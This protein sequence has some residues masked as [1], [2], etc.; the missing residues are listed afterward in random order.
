MKGSSAAHVIPVKRKDGGVCNSQDELLSRWSE[1][2]SEALNHP[3]ATSCP[4]LDEEQVNSV[5]D[6]DVAVDP[7]TTDEIRSAVNKLKLGRAAGGDA[8]APEMLK[9][10]IELTSFILDKIF[11]HVW[12]SGKVP[13]AWKEGI[14]VSLYKGKGLRDECSSY[15][16]PQCARQRF[17]SC[18]PG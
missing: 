16:P 3:N 11:A 6:G 14:I 8:I 10:A 2:Y 13:S 7:Q 9:L 4:D 18:P 1:H 12:L 17:C 15:L 5:D